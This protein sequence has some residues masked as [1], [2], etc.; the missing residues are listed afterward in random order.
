MKMHLPK[1]KGELNIPMI[2]GKIDQFLFVILFIGTFFSISDAQA[3]IIGFSGDINLISAPTS[4]KLGDLTSDTAI[5]GFEEAQNFT[6]G[7]DLFVNGKGAGFYL[8][9]GNP[10]TEFIT[11]GT[12]VNT[13][14]F[15]EDSLATDLTRLIGT[16]TFDSDILGIIFERSE[17]NNTDTILGNLGTAY[18]ALEP[19]SD[20][21]EFEAGGP[22]GTSVYDCA[23]ISGDLRTITLDLSSTIYIDQ[24]RVLTAS[25]P[26]PGTMLLLG[27]GLAGL[28]L[29]RRRFK[30]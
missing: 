27:S 19:S 1:I 13:Y 3:T 25:V 12:T 10:A 20:F 23:T 21:R 6:L 28:V 15:H 5:F 4:V 16:V 22:C 17:L 30:E 18:S 11:A 29:M 24:I 9:T 8:G 7:S 2:R 14:F 26:E